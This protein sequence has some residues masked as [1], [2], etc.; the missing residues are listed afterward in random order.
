MTIPRLI[1]C[2]F[3]THAP[4]T[5]ST[6]ASMMPGRRCGTRIWNYAHVFD[7]LLQPHSLSIL[8]L[9]MAAVCGAERMQ[10]LWLCPLLSLSRCYTWYTPAP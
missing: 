2:H 6:L 7:D 9:V 3:S 4:A 8:L 5:A 1:A 10:C